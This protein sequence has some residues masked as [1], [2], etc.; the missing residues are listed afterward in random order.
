MLIQT[1]AAR[2]AAIVLTAFF[3]CGHASATALTGS[4][5]HLALPTS[6]P[7]G[8]M[9]TFVSPTYAAGPTFPGTWNAPANPA[10]IG[11][12]SGTGA[13]PSTTAGAGTTRYD[14]TGLSA[15]YLPSSTF[16][17]FGDVDAGSGGSEQFY[18]RAFDTTAAHALI[19]TPWLSEPVATWGTGATSLAAMPGWAWN[20]SPG[21]YKI[22]GSTASFAG[23]PNLVFALLSEVPIGYLEVKK[24]STNYG[25]ALA[26]PTFPVPEPSTLL[27]FG[28]GLL[29]LFRN[30]W[31]RQWA[32]D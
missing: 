20:S 24:I 6:P 29:G 28:T 18:F 10:W 11:T 5:S 16:F 3:T 23:N 1:K 7:P 17:V 30:G 27:L 14:F 2:M 15:G 4:G 22:D 32:A 8:V 19:T 21:V 12:F 25:L 26:A 31:R 13:L 9:P